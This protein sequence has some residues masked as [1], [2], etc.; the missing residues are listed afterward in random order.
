MTQ[1]IKGITAKG[2]GV[3]VQTAVGRPLFNP[4]QK[5]EYNFVPGVIGMIVLLIFCILISSFA[6]IIS[7]YSESARQAPLTMF[8]F[9]VIFILMSGLLT[10]IR[11]MPEWA[12]WLSTL[13]PMRHIIDA[14]RL[15][16]V[17]EPTFSE[18]LPQLRTLMLFA[19]ITS[20]WAIV[21]Y[22]KNEMFG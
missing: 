21:S 20:V 14:L 18:L 4:Q 11:S 9:L 16:F 5:S 7:N 3:N 10:P 13:D 1:I 19:T 22:R 15:I 8:F 12:Q 17:K 2:S 6:L